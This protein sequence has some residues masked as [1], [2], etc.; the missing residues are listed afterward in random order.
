MNLF[1]SVL[2]M[3]PLKAG[4]Y[5]DNHIVHT[6]TTTTT[7]NNNGMS[8]NSKGYAVYIHILYTYNDNIKVTDEL[9]MK[10]EETEAGRKQT[11]DIKYEILFLFLLFL[12]VK[13][14][15]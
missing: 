8:H 10:K 6:T 5:K 9:S 14:I 4:L 7:N 1:M 13:K 3:N 15:K 12:S 2:N 11:N